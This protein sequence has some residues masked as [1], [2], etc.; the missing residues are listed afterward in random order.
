MDVLDAIETRKSVRA[1]KPEVQAAAHDGAGLLR[2]EYVILVRGIV[3]PRSEE[4]INPKMPTGKGYSSVNQIVNEH[5][6][7]TVCE[8][9]M[10][11][12]IG[13]C[14]NS[15]CYKILTNLKLSV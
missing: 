3:E 15:P 4:T 6:L 13:E 5:R 9:S 10:C 7:S 1:F 12:N 11:P 8:E 2:N 14:W